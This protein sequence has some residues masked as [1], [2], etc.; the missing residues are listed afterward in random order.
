QGKSPGMDG[1]PID[2]LRLDVEW[3]AIKLVPLFNSIYHSA[4]VPK[5]W[6]NSIVVPIFKKGDRNCQENYRPI[7]LLPCISKIYAKSL[8]IKLEEW[9]LTKG[10]PGKEQAGFKAGASTLDQC[11][12]L[13]HLVDKYVMRNKRKLFVAFVDLKSAFDSVDRN[14]LWTKLEHL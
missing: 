2:L 14:K 12:V 3:W 5:S 8:L 10:L 9:M 11:L 7:S 13:S 4:L 6:N 1:I